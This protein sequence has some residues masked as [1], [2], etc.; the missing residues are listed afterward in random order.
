MFRGIGGEPRLESEGFR[1]VFD[2]DRP[3]PRSA[4][5]ARPPVPALQPL[6]FHTPL[7]LPRAAVY[8]T[9]W[10][11][12]VPADEVPDERLKIY[13]RLYHNHVP[14][15]AEADVVTYHQEDDTLEL[16]PHAAELEPELERRMAEE[17]PSRHEQLFFGE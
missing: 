4:L 10:T 13:L 17:L 12:G 2:H 14:R 16:G 1:Q 3:V 6:V 5:V 8:V 15:L 9:E 11:Q 7:G